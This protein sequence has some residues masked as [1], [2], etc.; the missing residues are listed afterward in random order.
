MA[1]ICLKW[2]KEKKDY[3][4]IKQKAFVKEED[5]QDVIR[6]A[7]EARPDIEDIDGSLK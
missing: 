6:G 7:L 5:L 3:S 4:I 1:S 2:R